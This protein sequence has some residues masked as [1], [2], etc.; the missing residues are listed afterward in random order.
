M[1]DRL[2]MAPADPILGL[3]EA[4]RRDPNPEK[5]SLSAGVYKDAAGNT[6]V[7]AAVKAAETMILQN[8]TSKTYLGID[9]SPEYA[10]VVQ[11]LLFGEDHPVPAA[12]L[13]VTA[14]TPGGTGGLRVAADLIQVARADACVWVSQPTWP[15]HPNVF[16]A[17]GLKVQTYPY[18]D[19]ASNGLAFDAMLATL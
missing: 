19:A 3:E 11:G 8:E 12:G 9:G 16:R 15:N 17:A 5:I 7:L 10:T 13:A 4:F 1:F 18:F 2:E 6:P 14:H